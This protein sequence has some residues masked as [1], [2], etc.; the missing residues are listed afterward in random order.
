MKPRHG[1]RWV[2]IA[3]VLSLF[4]IGLGCGSGDGGGGGEAPGPY[5]CEELPLCGADR[6]SS[7]RP[8]DAVHVNACCPV[9][10]PDGGLDKP[11]ASIDAALDAAQAGDTVAVAAG[12]YDPVEISTSVNLLGAGADRCAVVPSSGDA[13]AM[14]ITGT[15]QV[16]VSGLM[17]S[18]SVEALAS[19]CSPP[20]CMDRQALTIPAGFGLVVSESQDVTISNVAVREFAH[21]GEWTGTGIL[22]TESTGV[23]L[24]DIAVSANARAGIVYSGSTGEI[25]G[26][27]LHHNGSGADNAAL[28]IVD[29]SAVLVGSDAVPLESAGSFA[30]GG[31]LVEDNDAIGVFVC[32]SSIS[33]LGSKVR[34]NLHGGAAFDTA[35]P[36]NAASMIRNNLF[37]G[38]ASFGISLLNHTADVISNRF[39][40]TTDCDG[41][42]VGHCVNVS[43]DDP[44]NWAQ[45]AVEDNLIS[46]CAGAGIILNGQ[47]IA[48]VEGNS[49]DNALRWGGIW[50]QGGID[51][52]SLAS[53]AIDAAALVG[54]AVTTGSRAQIINNTVNDTWEESFYNYTA[55]SY[56]DMAD[57]IVVSQVTDT[58][59]VLLEANTVTNSGRA[60]IIIDDAS[61][62]QVVFAS[63]QEFRNKVSGSG[64][65]E[66]VLQNGAEPIAEAQNLVEN[67]VG[68]SD[69]SDIVTD[70]VFSIVQS[71]TTAVL[72]SPCVPPACMD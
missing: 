41:D 48:T 45:V 43:G 8:D 1:T 9:D 19:P 63:E 39:A 24:Q 58:A 25:T 72:S 59:G 49:I 62:E 32:E 55:D 66:I 51:V 46:D 22:V 44:M 54:I 37:E 65:A 71:M 69:L 30:A 47:V 26:A 20:A 53:N 16:A 33:F 2:I 5:E 28:A 14:K 56:V 38:N 40:G 18:G 29:D 12:T 17:L 13:A 52:V 10:D 7:D 70:Q 57:G 21:V 15:Q 6:Y 34:G 35:A 31:C 61:T 42:C 64:E 27:W 50:A 11:Y 68:L 67:V 60:G 23:S 36:D 3:L 4:V